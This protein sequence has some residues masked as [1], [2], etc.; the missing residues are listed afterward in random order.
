MKITRRQLRNLISEQTFG[1]S[2]P[3][4]KRYFYSEKPYAGFRDTEQISRRGFNPK[5]RGLWYACGDDWREWVKYEMP[6]WYEA[7]NHLYEV[8][9]NPKHI[10]FITN[11]DQF[12]AF[13][14]EFGLSGGAE[15]MFFDGEAG[16]DWVRVSMKYAG[17]EICPYQSQFRM[18]SNWYYPWDVA[19]GCIWYSEGVV[20]VTEVPFDTDMHGQSY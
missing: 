6:H 4:I 3:V 12:K 15:P 20:S 16:I 19:S 11:A 7:Y 10:L 9:I 5:P 8:T 2:N 13:E 14:K 17:I 1:T 18:S